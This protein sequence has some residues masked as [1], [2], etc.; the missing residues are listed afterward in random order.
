MVFPARSFHGLNN[1][2]DGLLY[3]LE[4][5]V[6][7]HPDKILDGT[8]LTTSWDITCSLDGRT[9]KVSCSDISFSQAIQ[10]GKDAG[11]LGTGPCISQ[12]ASPCAASL[13]RVCVQ[14]HALTLSNATGSKACGFAPH[15]C[16]PD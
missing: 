9:G 8:A 2:G 10:Q 6:P 5:M 16:M 11:S 14:W 15:A 7:E 3:A 12:G 4:L 1:E 13:L